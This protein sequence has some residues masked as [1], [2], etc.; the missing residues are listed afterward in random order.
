VLA[1]IGLVLP[2]FIVAELSRVERAS[3]TGQGDFELVLRALFYALLIHV[4]ALPWTA[5]LVRDIG[6]GENWTH[7]VAALVPYAA[8]VLLV[9]PTLLGLA[10]N[11][12]LRSA[13]ETG[14]LSWVHAALGARDARDGFDFGFGRLTERGRFVIVRRK[15]GT[16]LAATFGDR[17]W[18]GRAPEP[19][20]LYLEQVRSLSPDGEIGP[21]LEP[22]HAVWINADGVDS[23]FV[24]DPRGTLGAEHGS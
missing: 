2:G 18:A 6:G 10:L 23:I 4:A 8:A 20:D 22:E 16:M 17:S 5:T 15:D 1:T 13:E 9:A 11:R 12:W 21:P 14:N 3:P 19:H 24:A 7:H